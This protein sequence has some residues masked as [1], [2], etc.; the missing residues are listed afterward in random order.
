[1]VRGGC[2]MK[3]LAGIDIEALS[4]TRQLIGIELFFIRNALLIHY[5]QQQKKLR[6]R[7]PARVAIKHLNN[8]MHLKEIDCV[9]GRPEATLPEI[10]LYLP[11]ISNDTCSD[12]DRT[13]MFLIKHELADYEFTFATADGRTQR[14]K[15]IHQFDEEDY[16]EQNE[17]YTV[18]LRCNLALVAKNLQKIAAMSNK[19]NVNSTIAEVAYILSSQLVNYI[20]ILLFIDDNPE[21]HSFYANVY[22]GFALTLNKLRDA[23]D[24]DA[25][26]SRCQTLRNL[27]LC[28][29]PGAPKTNFTQSRKINLNNHAR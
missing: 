14:F 24:H 2:R 27:F 22:Y 8:Y 23:P 1:M 5:Q 11:D 12:S 15:Y 10:L 28:C 4:S 7:D 9:N 25:P 20:D 18:A 16:A 13:L 26:K 29:Y 21:L 3:K 19:I 6:S 17:I